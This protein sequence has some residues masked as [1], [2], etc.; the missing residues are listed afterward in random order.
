MRGV[1]LGGGSPSSRT[2]PP[3]GGGLGEKGPDAHPRGLLEASVPLGPGNLCPPP[4]YT[5]SVL[6]TPPVLPP[7][8]RRWECP[9]RHPSASP[10]YLL[11]RPRGWGGGSKVR[12]TI[13][14]RWEGGVSKGALCWWGCPSGR[15][16]YL[17]REKTVKNSLPPPLLDT[18]F[19][20]STGAFASGRPPFCRL[21]GVPIRVPEN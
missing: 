17:S 1:G 19:S 13:G 16:L 21:G 6:S 10:G 4:S 3:G 7:S 8:V 14:S 5:R 15:I 9:G 18:A 11:P 20:F 12:S 2:P